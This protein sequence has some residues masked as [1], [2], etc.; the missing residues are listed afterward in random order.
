M[1]SKVTHRFFQQTAIALVLWGMFFLLF[2]GLTFSRFL[3]VAAEVPHV[4]LSAD[5][6]TPAMVQKHIF[7]PEDEE[8]AGKALGPRSEAAAKL[9]KEVLFTG[10][11][12]SPQGKWAIIRPKNK[13]KR[14]DSSWRLREGDEI[15]GY[16]IE[17]IGSNYIVLV[18]ND[19]PVR[20]GLYRGG[21][22]RPAPPA[23]P[24]VP[25][26]PV[27]AAVA[28][29]SGQKGTAASAQ[30]PS[31]KRTSNLSLRQRNSNPAA[32]IPPASKGKKTTPKSGGATPFAELLKRAQQNRQNGGAVSENPFSRMIRQQQ[33][34][35]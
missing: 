27:P 12:H 17:E 30:S 19:K 8:P 14:E 15:K 10:V 2:H 6:S 22:K 26:T 13:A 11:I 5:D 16:H 24:L 33:Q 25:L 4:E 28:A 3:A 9:E 18:K 35:K 20:L 23:E 7:S 34:N 21:K 32:T 29:S 1:K 31:G